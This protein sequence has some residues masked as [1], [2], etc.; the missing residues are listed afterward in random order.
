MSKSA[1]TAN[2]REDAS[3]WVIFSLCGIAAFTGLV[4]GNKDLI[5]IAFITLGSLLAIYV[6][7]TVADNFRMKARIRKASK[8]TAADMF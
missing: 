1:E 5:A 2:R 6:G 7:L 3:A 4:I 8:R